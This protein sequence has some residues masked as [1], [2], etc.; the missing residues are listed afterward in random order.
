MTPKSF[1]EKDRQ[2]RGDNWIEKEKPIKD[3]DPTS[4]NRT[5]FLIDNQELRVSEL[6]LFL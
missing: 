4:A 5:L 3:I 6:C 2:K 1:I